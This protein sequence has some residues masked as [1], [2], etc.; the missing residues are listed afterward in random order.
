MRLL[1]LLRCGLLSAWCASL[2]EAFSPHRRATPFLEPQWAIPTSQSA[3]SGLPTISEAVH[4]VQATAKRIGDAMDTQKWVDTVMQ[5]NGHIFDP[6]DFMSECTAEY[7]TEASVCKEFSNALEDLEVLI[8]GNDARLSR[9]ASPFLATP[10]S[11]TASS[12]FSSSALSSSLTSDE[13]G[14][15]FAYEGDGLKWFVK[16]ETFCKPFPVVKPHLEAHRAWVADLRLLAA[17]SSTPSGDDGGGGG[18][19]GGGVGDLERGATI[20]SGYRLGADGKPGGGGLMMF[21]ARDLAA[22]EALVLQD[23]LVANGCVDWQLNEW[24]AEV[25]DIAIL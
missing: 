16:T 14:C 2:V 22:A 20:T 11:T 7:G 24:V 10:S 9:E 6:D 5:S 1:S 8:T 25:G 13:D 19:G 18:G 15:Y 21:R 23:P 12:F 3:S 17:S 4:A